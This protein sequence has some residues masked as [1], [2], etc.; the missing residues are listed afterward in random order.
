MSEG[1]LGLGRRKLIN[2][3]ITEKWNAKDVKEKHYSY[4]E[5]LFIIQEM[6]AEENKGYLQ[7]HKVKSG[8]AN[9]TFFIE[10]LLYRNVANFDSM[11]VLSASK[12]LGKSS[13]AIMMA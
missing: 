2:K 9:F 6:L 10:H 4:N 1:S 12:G 8:F 3:I 11:V 5:M 13:A 7:Q